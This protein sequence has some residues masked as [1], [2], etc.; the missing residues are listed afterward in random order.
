MIGQHQ[1]L[2]DVH[3]QM[4]LTLMGNIQAGE[5]QAEDD[6]GELYAEVA[7][8]LDGVQGLEHRFYETTMAWEK[9]LR[10]LIG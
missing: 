2:L 3:L 4:A 6:V 9:E 5:E 1:E 10:D 7:S 8:L